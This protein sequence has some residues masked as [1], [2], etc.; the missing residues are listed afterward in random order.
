MTDCELTALIL[1]HPILAGMTCEEELAD[2]VEHL[3]ICAECRQL[4]QDMASAEIHNLLR[5][6]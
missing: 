1:R 4:Q 5:K 6:S 3:K 2:A